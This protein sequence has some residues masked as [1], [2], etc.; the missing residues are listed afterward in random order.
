MLI[1]IDL[2]GLLKIHN[3][4]L[5]KISMVLSVLKHHFFL[6]SHRHY[7]KGHI[8]QLNYTVVL[9]KVQTCFNYPTVKNPLMK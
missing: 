8:T 1:L 4:Y 3:I 7:A 2:R 6:F 5:S 9:K